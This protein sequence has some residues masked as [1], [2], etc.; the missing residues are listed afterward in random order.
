MYIIVQ[1]QSLVMIQMTLK[2]PAEFL[3]AQTPTGMPPHRLEFK[4]G[5]V[6]MLLKNINPKMGLCNG[7]RLVVTNLHTNFLT[8]KIIWNCNKNDIVFLLRIILTHS[9][10]I[11]SF[12]L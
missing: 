6:V 3:H 4:K 11:L 2:Y 7:T 1:T 8:A 5:T 9:D 10:I 12:I